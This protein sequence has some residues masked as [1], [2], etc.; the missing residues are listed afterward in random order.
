MNKITKIWVLWLALWTLV[1]TLNARAASWD[2]QQKVSLVLNDW[3]NSCTISDFNL[4]SHVV[5]PVDQAVDVDDDDFNCKFL[6][7]RAATL[8]ISLTNLSWAS[9]SIPVQNFTWTFSNFVKQG[10]IDNGIDLAEFIFS[11]T[12]QSFYWKEAN[13]IWELT[14]N[15]KIWWKVPG[16]TPAWTYTG[17]LDL[18]IQ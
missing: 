1:I 14:W 11:A 16:W 2:A 13:T 3:N 15:L 17:T 6:E 8:A 7:S 9:D 4:G 18:V 5:S 12:T 10:T